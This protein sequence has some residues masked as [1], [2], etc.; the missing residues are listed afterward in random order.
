METTLLLELKSSIEEKMKET[1]NL[2][3]EMDYFCNK[4]RIDAFQEVIELINQ[5]LD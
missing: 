2:P 5:K 1:S 3:T 4:S